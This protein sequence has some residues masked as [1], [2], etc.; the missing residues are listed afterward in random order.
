M[1]LSAN[2]NKRLD[3]MARSII[4]RNQYSYARK[5]YGDAHPRMTEPE[6]ASRYE[7]RWMRFNQDLWWFPEG[8]FAGV[9]V[10]RLGL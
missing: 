3:F 2:E 8:T 6:R 5:L 1:T 7:A 4:K 9:A 10:R